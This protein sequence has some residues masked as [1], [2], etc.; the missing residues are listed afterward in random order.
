MELYRA[1]KRCPE[2]GHFV[3]QIRAAFVRL[4]G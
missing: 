3:Q 4:S 1:G 2:L